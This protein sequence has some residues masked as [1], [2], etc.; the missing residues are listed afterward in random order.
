MTYNTELYCISILLL[1]THNL[2]MNS[3]SS[4]IGVWKNAI[5]FQLI[6]QNI[7]K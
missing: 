5:Q 1:T 3:E 4:F 2:S 7:T 6:S